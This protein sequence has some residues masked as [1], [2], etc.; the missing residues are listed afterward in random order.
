MSHSKSD[1]SSVLLEAGFYFVSLSVCVC[2]FIQKCGPEDIY[3]SRWFCVSVYVSASLSK[4]LPVQQCHKQERCCQQA[5]LSQK[6]LVL[7]LV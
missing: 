2:V 6:S 3:W 4:D 1:V 5:E 7:Q